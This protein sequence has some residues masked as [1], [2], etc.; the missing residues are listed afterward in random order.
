MLKLFA[1]SVNSQAQ[2]TWTY[3]VIYIYIYMH[4]AVG[5]TS[6]IDLCHESPNLYGHFYVRVIEIKKQNWIS[7]MEYS[8]VYQ[9]LENQ[10]FDGTHTNFGIQ[11]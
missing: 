3:W 10:K 4:A 9:I 1:C 2:S 11:L 6:Y 5:L 7:I 8:V